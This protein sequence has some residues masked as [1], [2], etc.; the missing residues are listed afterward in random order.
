[1]FWFQE[2]CLFIQTV[3]IQVLLSHGLHDRSDLCYGRLSA[4]LSIHRTDHFFRDRR[5][6][7]DLLFKILPGYEKRNDSTDNAAQNKI[8]DREPK[9]THSNTLFLKQA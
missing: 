8:Q 6:F 3:Q 7:F 5:I 4:H 9:I 2:Y 1:M